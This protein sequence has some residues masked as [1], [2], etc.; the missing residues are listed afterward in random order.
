MVVLS[1]VCLLTGTGCAVRESAPRTRVGAL[2]FPGLA[3]LYT[4]ADPTKLGVHQYG[5]NPRIF[6]ADEKERGI[7]YTERAGFVDM[8]HIRESI[9][10]CRFDTKHLRAALRAGKTHFTLS[11]KDRTRLQITLNYPPDWKQ[12]PRDER[13]ALIDEITTRGGQMITLTRMTW[14]ETATWFGYHRVPF[15]DEQPSSFTYDDTMSHVVGTRVAARAM[16]MQGK[17]SFDKAATEAL[18]AELADLGA[19]TPDETEKAVASVE[20]YWWADGAPLKR[21]IDVADWTSEHPVVYPWLVPPSPGGISPKAQ[22][23]ELPT[24][25]DVHGRDLSDMITVEIEP[26]FDGADEILARLPSEST[27]RRR[28]LNARTELPQL[29]AIV[30]SQM[31]AKFGDTCAD[32]PWAVGMDTATAGAVPPSPTSKPT[33]AAATT[34]VPQR[35]LTH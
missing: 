3:T 6:G 32:P 24:L 1:V 15:I 20:G 12:L 26:R 16:L 25:H 7:I 34:D 29:L 11:P 8:A 17:R 30:R 14:H 31:C 9:D 27:E 10:W 13:D 21:H 2:P 22:P 33:H 23:F 28:R 4:T 18:Y 5:R 35:D 19:V